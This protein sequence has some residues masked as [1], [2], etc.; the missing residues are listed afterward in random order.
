MCSGLKNLATSGTIRKKDRS[1]RSTLD[2][3]FFNLIFYF[4]LIF[5]FEKD[6]AISIDDPYFLS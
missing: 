3:F 5:I 4:Y 1:S 6:M 2:F